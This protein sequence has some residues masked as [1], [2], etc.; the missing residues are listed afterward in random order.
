MTRP[1]PAP[2]RRL[3]LTVL[4]IALA[5]VSSLLGLFR[6]QCIARIF[7]TSA[8]TDAFLVAW[9]VPDTVTPLL[10]DGALVLLLVPV[11]ARALAED[12]SI[13]PAVRATLASYCLALVGLTGLVAAAAPVLV[14]LFTPGLADPAL[15]VRCLRVAASTVLTLGLA[16]YL[17]AAL[18]TAGRYLPTMT[19][20]IAFNIGV[21]AMVLGL[22]RSAGV[23]AGALG[24]ALGGVLTVVVQLH[25]F[26]RGASLR[27]LRLLSP[28]ATTLAVA[29]ILPVASY[30]I[31]RH[32]QTYVERYYGSGLRPGAI[33]VLNYAERIGQIPVQAATML[34]VVSFPLLAGQAAA[35]R[36]GELRRGAERDLR[37]AAYLIAPA[38]GLFVALAP[39][40]VALLFQRGAFGAAQVAATAA[41]LRAYSLGLPGQ[42][43]VVVGAV[44]LSSVTT[45]SWN[46]ARAAG[47]GLALT[48]LADALL[49]H[50][51][52]VPGLALGNAAGITLT[53]GMVIATL[54][55]RLAGFDA[56]GLLGCTLRCTAAGVV[57]GVAGAGCARLPL[58]AAAAVAV[59]VLAVAAVYLAATWLAGLDEARQTCR[60]V[61]ATATAIAAAAG[62]IAG[63][64]RCRPARQPAEHP[65]PAEHWPADRPGRDLEKARQHG[66]P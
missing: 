49:V 35:G 22:H 18:R 58:P 9:S 17:S 4:M 10:L 41:G 55:R 39:Q 28:R 14:H 3:R 63:R 43:M 20:Y 36:A 56:A 65:Q 53:G 26:L 60:L 25:P 15:A 11:F 62:A 33:S 24:M 54:R 59:G 51:L 1:K 5:G 47:A 16:G 46:L 30:T 45:R 42:A 40:V 2:V 27:R 52:G 44:C 61:R 12:R 21:L 34:A 66:S 29:G 13:Q 7:G 38:V 37:M 57:A 32:A 48:A 31:G 19:V 50:R 6:D 64:A 23:Y 8:Q